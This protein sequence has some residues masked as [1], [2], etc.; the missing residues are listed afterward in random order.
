MGTPDLIYRITRY[1]R[2]SL[3]DRTAGAAAFFSPVM[4]DNTSIP[5]GYFHTTPEIFIQVAGY[6]D[7][8]LPWT[9]FR[10][11]SSQ[12]CVIPAYAPHLERHCRL[13]N[14]FDF[15]VGCF[16][17]DGIGWHEATLNDNDQIVGTPSIFCHI[18][19]MPRLILLCEQNT[20]AASCSSKYGKS[21][22]KG[23]A[24]LLLST[25]LDVM[26]NADML[27]QAEHPKVSICKQLIRDHLG[28]NILC[29]KYLARMTE[30]SPNYLSTLFHQE[31]HTRLND[32][33]TDRR[34]ER[35]Q[36]LLKHSTLNI[37][38]IAYASGYDD[39]GY[40]ARVF[41]KNF[42]M[43]PRDYRRRIERT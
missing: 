39:S 19:Q 6:T 42:G 11:A 40:M 3:E 37:E 29:V 10:L 8:T 31:T 36:G 24:V 15:I 21:Q 13:K 41:V 38:E 30:C 2:K 34:L 27:S 25:L 32:Y 4:P 1:L 35:V 12:I 26:E 22:R 23:A 5:S 20:I 16:S 9:H 18:P 7:F 33:I 28:E 43:T 17:S 14:R